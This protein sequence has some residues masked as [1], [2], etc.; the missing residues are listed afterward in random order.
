MIQCFERAA[1]W[2]KRSCGNLNTRRIIFETCFFVFIIFFLSKQSF[3]YKKNE[4]NKLLFLGAAIVQLVI[5]T[6][7]D[8]MERGQQFD[9]LRVINK[10]CKGALGLFSLIN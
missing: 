1:A 10:L 4:E 6:A 7:R 5:K 3:F 9:L 2:P 8:E